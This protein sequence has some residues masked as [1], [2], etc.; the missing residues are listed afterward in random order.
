MDT[1]TPR[2]QQRQNSREL[3]Q[4]HHKPARQVGA[5][6]SNTKATTRPTPT[7]KTTRK[8]KN[9]RRSNSA[10]ESR[11]HG[12]S[13]SSSSPSGKKGLR[14]VGLVRRGDCNLGG[15]VQE[16]KERGRRRRG[17]GRARAD[18]AGSPRSGDGRRRIARARGGAED[19]PARGGE[20]D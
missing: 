18:E 2:S 20:G 6:K 12:R 19:R 15:G 5:V 17:G 16:I 3:E 7:A 14:G 13:S 10:L 4:L 1:I 9:R 11:R 8:E